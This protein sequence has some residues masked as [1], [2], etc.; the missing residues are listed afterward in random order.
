MSVAFKGLCALQIDVVGPDKDLHSGMYGGAVANPIHALVRI[1]DSMRSPEGKILVDGFYDDVRELTPEEQ[2]QI[3]RVP[4]DEEEYMQEIGVDSDCTASQ[5]TRRWSAPG[6]APRS[7][8][9]ASG[10]DFRAKA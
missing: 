8:L 10:V 9:T 3:A 7:R 6:P 5:D 1:L 2:A 4:L